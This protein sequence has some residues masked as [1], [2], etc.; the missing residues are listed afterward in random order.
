VS[1]R[2]MGWAW[3][4]RGL[5]PTERLT[6]MALASCADS[7]GECFP[8]VRKIATEAGIGERSVARA[9]NRLEAIGKLKR[10]H[11]RR[12]DGS[13]MASRYFLVLPTAISSVGRDSVAAGGDAGAPPS[14]QVV[15]TP[16]DSGSPGTDSQSDQEPRQVTPS[17]QTPS[18]KHSQERVSGADAPPVSSAAGDSKDA[19]AREIYD[20]YKQRI[21]PQS[22]LCPFAKI[23]ARRKTF[24]RD[25]LF[26]AID[27]FASE[28]WWMRHNARQGADWFF[29][30]DAQIERFMNLS[31]AVDNHPERYPGEHEDLAEAE[32]QARRRRLGRIERHAT[33]DAELVS[34][35][36]YR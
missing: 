16:T 6:L 31:T 35:D 19:E 8:G 34:L 18:G 25:D 36:R 24:S 21:Q 2:V 5:T 17:S 27:R 32:A 4:Q 30:S 12:R 14:S 3:E 7:N 22:R 23:R 26:E 15:T 10:V 28:P 9:L 13:L 29:R 11:Q 20:H 33:E 1:F